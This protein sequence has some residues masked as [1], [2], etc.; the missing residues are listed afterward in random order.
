MSSVI[1]TQDHEP[2]PTTGAT[3]WL[4]KLALVHI[5]A[6]VLECECPHVFCEVY[7]VAPWPPYNVRT[8]FHIR[9]TDELG[10]LCLLYYAHAGRL[11]MSVPSEGRQRTE[12]KAEG[13]TK[14][15]CRYI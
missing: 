4:T 5:D 12:F 7:T 1:G 10:V 13:G 14:E 9:K 11:A 3:R 15:D 6:G 2:I 8:Y